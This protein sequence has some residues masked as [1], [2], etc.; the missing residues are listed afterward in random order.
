[1]GG[2]IGP[3]FTPGPGPLS[4]QPKRFLWARWHGPRL[5]TR[6]TAPLLY[7]SYSFAG[8]AICPTLLRSPTLAC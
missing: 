4:Q 5:V 7:P 1:V 6:I 8:W 2:V 3:G